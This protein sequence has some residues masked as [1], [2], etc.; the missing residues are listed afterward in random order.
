MIN[1]SAMG[2]VA[3][4]VAK[5]PTVMTS[6]E[7]LLKYLM[8]MYLHEIKSLNFLPWNLILIEMED[9]KNALRRYVEN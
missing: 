8:Y 4:M 6:F 9:S 5:T 2:K 3:I 7:K 1:A